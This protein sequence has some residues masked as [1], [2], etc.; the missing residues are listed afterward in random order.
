MGI[1]TKASLETLCQAESNKQCL[2]CGAPI[3][4]D[5]IRNNVITCSQCNTNYPMLLIGN[6]HIPFIFEDVDSVLY[7]WCAR[8]NGFKEKIDAELSDLAIQVKNKRNSKLTEKRLKKLSS[9]KKQ[10][11]E[12]LTSLLASIEMMAPKDEFSQNISIAKNQGIDS[13][14]NNVFRDWSW[15]NGETVELINIVR[16]LLSED[17]VAGKT[18]TLGAG[19]SRLSYDFHYTYHAEHSLLVDINPV[20]LGI[21]AN[22]IA[23][24]P[25]NIFEFPVAPLSLED[26]AVNQKCN[27]PYD[28]NHEACN[29][30]FL[31]A[32]ALN[33]P[34]CHNYFDSVLTPWVI[35]IV[36]I[37]FRELIPHINRLLKVGG[38]WINTGSLA[39]FHNNE[40]WN[41][42]QEEIID[43][44]KK[45]GFDNIEISREDI[46]YLRSPHSAHG[47]VESVFSFSASKK[48]ECKAPEKF[49]Y[50]PEWM[51]DYK[52]NIPV[53]DELVAKSSKYL[54][55]AQ[56][57]SAIDGK[58]SIN[59]IGRLVATQYGI[60]EESA[61]AAV[62]QVLL[63]NLK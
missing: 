38:K 8:L 59:E 51:C 42:S 26:F 1:H 9:S 11:R 48:F 56:I 49:N 50:V 2:H 17:Y 37:D 22:I 12:Q 44:L 45:Y 24:E 39:Y 61:R 43:L 31:L 16:D 5:A 19:A 58:R 63:D 3:S 52:L 27:L 40:T 6:V 10:Y 23:G 33:L 41:Y 36:P 14:I 46:N 34:L 55:Q 21:A 18:L 29:F 13:Y 7:G 20:L 57:L 53:Q 62:R 15:D 4:V 60:S 30:E 32:D 25:L 54:F 28:D 35:D 47:R